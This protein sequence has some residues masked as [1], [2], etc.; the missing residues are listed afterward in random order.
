MHLARRIQF[1][2]QYNIL[3]RSILISFSV[4]VSLFLVAFFERSALNIL[5]ELLRSLSFS[6]LL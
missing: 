1:T 6:E 3:L 5:S 4:Y 2:P